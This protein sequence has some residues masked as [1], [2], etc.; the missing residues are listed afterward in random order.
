MRHFLSKE[1]RMKTRAE[2]KAEGKE[3]GILEGIARS[4]RNLMQCLNISQGEA[5]RLLSVSEKDIPAVIEHL[6]LLS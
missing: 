6:K 5:L 4:V 2:G 3:E 1:E